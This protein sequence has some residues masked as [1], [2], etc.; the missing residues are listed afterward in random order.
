MAI[1]LRG[2]WEEGNRFSKEYRISIG[3]SCAFLQEGEHFFSQ[4]VGANHFTRRVHNGRLFGKICL[5]GCFGVRVL[6]SRLEKHCSSDCTNALRDSGN[7]AIGD[8]SQNKPA[9]PHK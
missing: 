2:D 7:H 5:H 6:C 4:T 8:H 1:S 9:S 3:L